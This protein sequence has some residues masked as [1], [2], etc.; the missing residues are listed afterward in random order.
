MAI[1]E[2]SA[3]ITQISIRV[4]YFVALESSFMMAGFCIIK[5][6]FFAFLYKSTLRQKRFGA[7]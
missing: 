6:V 2:A 5:A 7:K 3:I 1:T 4:S